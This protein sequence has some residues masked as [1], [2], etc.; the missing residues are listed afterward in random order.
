MKKLISLLLA[1]LMLTS[2]LTIITSAAG[3]GSDEPKYSTKTDGVPQMDYKSGL[4]F[5]KNPVITPEQKLALMDYRYGDD[6]YELY[7]DGYSGEVAIR[8]KATGD[9]LFTNP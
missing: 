9:T 1:V 7:V 2:A 6:K 3:T 4:D 5:D 8:S